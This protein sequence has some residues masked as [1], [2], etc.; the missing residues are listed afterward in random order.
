MSPPMTTTPPTAPPTTGPMIEL[1]DEN[2]SRV[3]GGKGRF[4]V[5]YDFFWLLLDPGL[6]D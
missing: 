3:E 6:S 2:V 1:G 5:I 4:L